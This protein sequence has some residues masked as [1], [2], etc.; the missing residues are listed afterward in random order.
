MVP[1]DVRF[2]GT[3]SLL[4]L[5]LWVLGPQ[6]EAPPR[7]HLRLVFSGDIIFGISTAALC[8]KVEIAKAFTLFLWVEHSMH[9]ELV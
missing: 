1:A 7:R 2:S 6:L 3:D 9:E 4:A 8:T 5:V